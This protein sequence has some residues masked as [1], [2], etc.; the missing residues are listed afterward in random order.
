MGMI[1]L[2]RVKLRVAATAFPHFSF[3]LA[4]YVKGSWTETPIPALP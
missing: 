1:E 2:A 3:V 4:R